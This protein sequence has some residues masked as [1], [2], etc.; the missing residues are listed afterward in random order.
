MNGYTF[1]IENITPGFENIIS[2]SEHNNDTK[3]ISHCLLIIVFVLLL[4]ALIVFIIY[5]WDFYIWK[6]PRFVFNFV[7]KYI[8]F[9]N[10]EIYYTSSS[11]QEIR[12][13]S[14]SG[15]NVTPYLKV[16]HTGCEHLYVCILDNSGLWHK[17]VIAVQGI[18]ESSISAVVV[19][20]NIK[21][22]QKLIGCDVIHVKSS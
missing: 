4:I 3:I 22:L 19:Q 21:K 10:G 16:K 8:S 5:C 20:N 13:V 9:F 12:I 18:I 11:W 1:L 14:V 6:N 15:Y 7:T 2:E 17:H